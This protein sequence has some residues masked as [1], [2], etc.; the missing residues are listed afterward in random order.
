[1]SV[2]LRKRKNADGTT[3]LRLDI[4]HNGQRTIETLKHLK[5]AKQSNVLDR[6]NNKELLKIPLTLLQEGL[7]IIRF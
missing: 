5:L 2:I 1:M 4:F 6:E 7:Y 3:S